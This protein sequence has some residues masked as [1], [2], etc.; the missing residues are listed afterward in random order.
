MA[1]EKAG[2]KSVYSLD[3][4]RM[5]IDNATWAEKAF[6]RY[7]AITV[8]VLIVV[9]VAKG[10]PASTTT[11]FLFGKIEVPH[12]LITKQIWI[13]RFFFTSL[14]FYSF[15]E[16]TL[17]I[18]DVNR[19]PLA[20]AYCGQ[21]S[22]VAIITDWWDHKVKL[23]WLHVTVVLDFLQKIL[24]LAMIGFIFIILWTL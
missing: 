21:K 3:S 8:A 12:S 16:W 22:F 11:I 2:S 23:K 4:L 5:R 7:I 9:A 6:I 19:H 18:I 24:F 13:I 15:V 1:D 17:A 14:L 20:E 10:G